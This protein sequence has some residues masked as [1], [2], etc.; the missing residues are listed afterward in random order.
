MGRF[1][2]NGSDY[3]RIHGRGDPIIPEV[4][5]HRRSV[6]QD[7][8]FQEGDSRAGDHGAL[9]LLLTIERVDHPAQI[10]SCRDPQ[11]LHFA[12]FRVH[13]D[14]GALGSIKPED[15]RK[16]SLPGLLIQGGCIGDGKGA[17]PDDRLSLT[18]GDS[19]GDSGNG[20]PRSF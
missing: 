5:V 12:R 6:L 1:D 4:P 2:K 15:G 19:H 8:L 7:Q 3:R 16:G 10:M 13:L 9:Y 20:S 18:V 14:I 11:D 17:P